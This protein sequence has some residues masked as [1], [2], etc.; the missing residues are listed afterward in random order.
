MLLP[1]RSQSKLTLVSSVIRATSSPAFQ[2]AKLPSWFDGPGLWPSG[3]PQN[4]E[5]L[6]DL[7]RR[8]EPLENPVTGTRVGIGIA[9][10]CDDIYLRDDE[11]DVEPGRLL[12][13]VKSGD[14]ASGSIGW[15]GTSL[16]NPWNGK[17]LVD[18]DE[19]PK[20]SQYF[21]R[22]KK[23]IKKRHVAQ[24]NPSNWYRTI[25]RITPGLIDRPKLLLPDIKAAAHPVLD[26]LSLIHISEPT[27]PY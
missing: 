12:P 21:D 11:P 2:A 9:T 22:N 25:D 17:G 23:R 3:S 18:L 20:L 24:M 27:R 13:I 26:P 5:L 15:S 4:L 7:E 14:I 19:Y 10:G 1:L 6:A 8:F 16:V